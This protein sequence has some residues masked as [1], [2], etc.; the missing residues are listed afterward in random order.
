MP[1]AM[2]VFQP[3]PK[4]FAIVAFMLMIAVRLLFLIYESLPGFSWWWKTVLALTKTLKLEGLGYCVSLFVNRSRVVLRRD[5]NYL[6]KNTH[7][8]EMGSLSA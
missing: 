5:R 7:D 6:D 1:E 8:V 3:N 2:V 4:S